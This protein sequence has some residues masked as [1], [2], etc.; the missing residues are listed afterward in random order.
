MLVVHLVAIGQQKIVYQQDYDYG[1]YPH[2]TNNVAS[3]KHVRLSQRL[4][5]N[6]GFEIYGSR[7][8]NALKN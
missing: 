8:K 6:P 7:T 3:S 4:F 2:K 5:H 1:E